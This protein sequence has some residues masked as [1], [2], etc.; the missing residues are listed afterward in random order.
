M[1]S[2]P[3][4]SPLVPHLNDV[5]LVAY[6]DGEMPRAELEAAR[7]H[8]ESCWICRS[9]LGAVQENID[10]FLQARKGLLPEAP[11]FAE[12]RVEQ[13][14]QRLV[15]HAATGERS[16]VS[17]AGQI[18]KPVSSGFRALAA[19]MGEH[20]RAVIASALAA[21]L[22]VVMFTD[23]LNTRVSADT[24]L[25]RAQSYET[26]HRAGK[27][28]VRK[29]SVR[30]ERI[31]GK[32]GTPKELGTIIA[33]RDSETPATYWNAQSVFGSFEDT[34]ADDVENIS[35]GVLRAVLP[36]EA[37]DKALIAYLS[38]QGWVPDVSVEGFRSLIR[39]RGT[40][41]VSAQKTGGVFELHYPFAPGHPSGI[42]EAQLRVDAKDYSPASVSIF[43]SA[44]KAGQEYRFTRMS[45]ATEPRSME[46]AHLLVPGSTDDVSASHATAR[47]SDAVPPLPRPVPLSYA[48]SHATV[49]EV[50][51][52]EA[53]HRVDACLGE[54]IYV[55]PM[56]DGSLLVQGLVDNPARREAIKQSLKAVAGPLRVEIYVPRELKSGSELYSPPDRFADKVGESENTGPSAPTTLA[57]LSSASMP[58]HDRIYK[59][60]S[61]PGVAPD[62]T[63]KEVA[64]FSNEVVTHARQTFLHAW[65]LKKLDREFSSERISGLPASALRQLEQIRKD[66][67]T[68][69]AN[70]AQR[71]A[72][73]L[74][75]IADSPLAANMSEAMGE[76]A[77]SDTLL[78]LAREQNDL[79][80][81]LFTTSP[82]GPE[83]VASLSR[84]LAVLRHMGG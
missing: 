23:V 67:Q 33:V 28:Q 81:S 53:L 64:I 12:S 73:M 44:E 77:D 79:V 84:L 3:K 6:Q 40:T 34:T 51:I 16:K 55:F 71:Q 42:T 61:R 37:G 4:K 62:D 69:I 26:E 39:T 22:L 46:L 5:Q 54:E 18:W 31:D 66:H 27:G 68:W 76:H 2:V 13:F 38:Q 7:D 8:V 63:E 17:A 78:R 65:A 24:V 49:E 41:E 56:S 74:S 72:E 47:R 52:A 15:R 70:L 36:A 82:Q 20:R 80:R 14:R 29:I 58:L 48:N 50:E 25:I 83:A 60:L 59:H 35:G 11:A 45:E 43:T 75:T 10:R 9:R 57:D 19:V 1:P 30:V 21:C 32:D